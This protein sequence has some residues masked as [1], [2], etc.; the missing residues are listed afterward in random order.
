MTKVLNKRQRRKFKYFHLHKID[1]FKYLWKKRDNNWNLINLI[2]EKFKYKFDLTKLSLRTDIIIRTEKK[3]WKT[4]YERMFLDRKLFYMF[5]YNL[6]YYNLRQIAIKAKKTNYAIALYLLL[7]ESRIDVIL[8]RINFLSSVYMIRQYIKHKTICINN[9]LVKS[10][11]CRLKYY[12]ILS[13]KN[14]KIKIKILKLLRRRINLVKNRN[15]NTFEINY[16]NYYEV[17]YPLLYVTILPIPFTLLENMY[18]SMKPG[19]SWVVKKKWNKIKKKKKIKSLIKKNPFQFL[20]FKL[21][22]I[23]E[24]KKLKTKLKLK[25]NTLINIILEKHKKNWKKKKVEKFYNLYNKK[26]H[27]IKPGMILNAYKTFKR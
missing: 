14:N 18:F 7:L 27:I 8:Y 22:Q 10:C 24:I 17:F 6:T 11:S 1:I 19:D 20:I 21:S 9:K 2:Y 15:L 4:M 3:K 26:N 23:K 16:P 12:D 13:F 25:P 5:Y